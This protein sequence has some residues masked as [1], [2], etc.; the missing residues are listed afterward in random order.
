[1]N[2]LP[3]MELEGLEFFKSKV[4][5]SSCY[6]EYGCGGSTLFAHNEAKVPQI[7]SVDT[8]L[9]WII[10]VKEQFVDGKSNSIIDHV[11]LGEIGDW[12]IPNSTEHYRDFHKYSSIPWIRAKESGLVPDTVLIDG[13]FRIACFL[14][15]L[16]CARV[17]TSIIFDD[18]LDRPEY[19]I[20]E[21]FC[22][23]TDR[24]GRMAGFV[25]IKEFNTND[26]VAL[27]AKYSLDW[28]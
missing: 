16:L 24:V 4:L 18:Y 27:Y 10:K 9:R 14:Y 7:I 3:H 5:R 22:R 1:M 8:D 13:R 20:I 12:G 23:V 15:S 11:D 2:P 6:L 17:G 19:F 28:S 26:L 25:V 21:Q